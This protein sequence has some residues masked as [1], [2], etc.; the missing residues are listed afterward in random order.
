MHRRSKSVVGDTSADRCCSEEILTY[1]NDAE[2]MHAPT[3]NRDDSPFPYK[4]LCLQEDVRKVVDCTGPLGRVVDM[5]SLTMVKDI[6]SRGTS[7][8]GAKPP[9]TTKWA[10]D[11][12]AGISWR[13]MG[14]VD[15]T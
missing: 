7:S 12:C 10:T 8:D 9:A 15:G 3:I 2:D 1:T 6:S 11:G 4:L 5:S 13:L 14:E